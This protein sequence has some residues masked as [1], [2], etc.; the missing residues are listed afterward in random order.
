MLWMPA[1]GLA[2]FFCRRA[3]RFLSPAGRRPPVLVPGRAADGR[4]APAGSYIFSQTI[5]SMRAGV[6]SRL[7]G[8]IIAGALAACPTLAYGRK[9]VLH[10]HVCVLAVK[11]TC[12]TLAQ[13]CMCLPQTLLVSPSRA[14]YMPSACRV[15][16]K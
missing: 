2:V 3:C 16:H 5:F 13:Y 6:R 14:L 1:P 7:H 10:A 8:C 15:P 11:N 4:D 9:L 12:T